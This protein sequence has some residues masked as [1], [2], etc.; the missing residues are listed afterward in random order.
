MQG[1]ITHTTLA[2]AA[3]GPIMESQRVA[4]EEKGWSWSF[5]AFILAA[6]LIFVDLQ[7]HQGDW[8]YSF[9]GQMLHKSGMDK[10]LVAAFDQ[11]AR[12]AA[13]AIK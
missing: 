8:Q 2:T 10:T 3:P 12:V 13:V 1:E 6:A 9:T 5:Y 4:E 11:A 7:E